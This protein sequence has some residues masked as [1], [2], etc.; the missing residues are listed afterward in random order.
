VR[1]AAA[2]AAPLLRP[3]GAG[4]PM[5]STAVPA[6]SGPPCRTSHRPSRCSPR[7]APRRRSAVT[8]PRVP[9]H[10]L[11]NR[12][13]G[14]RTDGSDVRE[15]KD[16]SEGAGAQG[17]APPRKVRFCTRPDVAAPRVERGG[18]TGVA[19]A[20]QATGGLHRSVTSSGSR[21]G[22]LAQAPDEATRASGRRGRRAVSGLLGT[23]SPAPCRATA[24]PAERTAP[25]RS[26]ACG[27]RSEDAAADFFRRVELSR[28][29]P[30]CST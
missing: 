13:H 28:L 15:E 29:P 11:R 12:A 1:Q 26:R 7:E 9:R 24:V 16:G 14:G 10:C 8:G 20:R 2:P 4:K 6:V 23:V 25:C 3:S 27:C 17:C 30:T 19:L 5:P 21:R 22:S 18:P